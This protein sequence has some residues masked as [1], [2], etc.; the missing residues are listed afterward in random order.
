MPMPL[1][2]FLLRITLASL[3][4]AALATIVAVFAGNTTVLWRIVLTCVEGS[5][6]AAVMLRVSRFLDSPEQRPAGIAGVGCVLGSFA[7]FL[8][9][10]WIDLLGFPH[11]G[12][13]FGTAFALTGSG[14]VATG[15]LALRPRKDAAWVWPV[16]TAVATLALPPTLLAIW[17]DNAQLGESCA[18]SIPLLLLGSL[19]L[20]GEGLR[21]RPWRL[22]GVPLAMASAGVGIAYAMQ[23][24]SSHEFWSWYVTL[25]AAL[26]VVVHAGFLS[27]LAL[28]AWWHVLRLGTIAAAVA[29]AA[30]VSWAVFVRPDAFWDE[31]DQTTGRFTATAGILAACGTLALAAFQRL[32]RRPVIDAARAEFRALTLVCPRCRTRQRAPIG[33]SCCVNCR[34]LFSIRVTEPRCAACGYSLLDLKTDRCPECG[35]PIPP[36]G[37]PLD[38]TEAVQV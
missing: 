30:G 10:T 33:E 37:P 3:G 13:L 8:L 5:I 26:V 29:T 9:C 36:L 1:R 31:F 2:Q 22:M 4:A 7:L 20:V 17:A 27:R 21:D 34:L 11:W 32:G 12:E 25:A 18:A 38:T 35:Q 15:A 28:T 6:A 16:A 24:K 14:A 19:C 23:P